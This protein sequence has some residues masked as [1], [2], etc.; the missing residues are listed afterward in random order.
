MQPSPLA[1]LAATC[2]KIGGV[3]QAHQND[4]QSD[5][6]QTQN[7]PVAQAIQAGQIRVVSAAVLQQLQEQQNRT[8]AQGQTQVY[9]TQ[10]L[11][12]TV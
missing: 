12:I 2:S 7:N 3:N 5:G 11:L 10:L 4:Q 9:R 1:L 6:H 8:Q